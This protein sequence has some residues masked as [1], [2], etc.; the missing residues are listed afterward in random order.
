MRIG[1]FDISW[2]GIENYKDFSYMGNNACGCKILSLGT[3]SITKYGQ[4]CLSYQLKEEEHARKYKEALR[5]QK[6]LKKS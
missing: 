4:E 6:S 5:K 1:S 3:F 2:D